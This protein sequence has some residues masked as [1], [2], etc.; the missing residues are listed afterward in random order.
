VW[1][2]LSDSFI[3]VSL[4]GT[5]HVL[6]GVLQHGYILTDSFGA[7][8]SI[9][10]FVLKA[11]GNRQRFQVD[12]IQFSVG[13]LRLSLLQVDSPKNTGSKR[14]HAI[15][16]NIHEMVTQQ[17]IRDENILRHEAE[18]F[19]KC[20]LLEHYRLEKKDQSEIN[21]KS[22]LLNSGRKFQDVSIVTISAKDEEDISLESLALDQKEE[23]DSDPG[24]P[25]E[26]ANPI[27]EQFDHAYSKYNGS[28]LFYTY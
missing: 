19:L 25:V 17:R 22:R 10:E 26:H 15:E 6:H 2:M 8:S 4:S 3:S 23:E 27:P 16:R 9:S 11:F 1:H 20:I 24:I 28:S 7:F 14:L 18:T 13:K 12:Q 21:L 5:R